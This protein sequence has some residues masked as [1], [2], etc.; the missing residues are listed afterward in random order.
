MNQIICKHF[1]AGFHTN[2]LQV[3]CLSSR[4]L[5]TPAQ[6]CLSCAASVIFRVNWLKVIERSTEILGAVAKFSHA[7]SQLEVK[8]QRGEAFL[9]SKVSN[10]QQN[11]EFIIKA[12]TMMILLM[13]EIPAHA[14]RLFMSLFKTGFI[15]SLQDFSHQWDTVW[16]QKA[17]TMSRQDP[18]TLAAVEL[19]ANTPRSSITEVVNA[20]QERLHLE[21]VPWRKF[22][23]P[24]GER[25]EHGWSMEWMVAMCQT[26]WT[27]VETPSPWLFGYL[28]TIIEVLP[29]EMQRLAVSAL[30]TLSLLRL[31]LAAQATWRVV[32]GVWDCQWNGGDVVWLCY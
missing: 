28:L 17:A 5:Q 14:D 1:H 3:K 32:P 31:R 7:L 6:P 8:Q 20:L 26:V 10:P 15:H 18:V 12:V 4:S 11:C 27:L 23:W 21:E 30:N 9:C 2:S 16:L 19:L 22:H 13:T 24:G 25:L 29:S